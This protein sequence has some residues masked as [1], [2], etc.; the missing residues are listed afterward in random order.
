MKKILSLIGLIILVTLFYKIGFNNIINAF[1]NIN[2]LILFGSLIFS[3]IVLIPPTIKWM[4]IL[5]QQ[6]VN[7]N[8]YTLAKIELIGTFYGIITPGRVGTFIRCFYLKDKIN[9]KLGFCMSSV[10][11]DKLLDMLAI[12][13][14]AFIGVLLIVHRVSGL[15]SSFIL[16]LIIFLATVIFFSSKKRAMYFFNI[17]YNFLIPNKYRKS[18]HGFFHSF[19]N[20]SIHPLHLILPFLIALISYLLFYT[21]TFIVAQA[22]AVNVPYLYFIPLL[23]LATI[24]GMLPVTIAGLGTREATLVGLFSLFNQD[25]SKVIAM[26]LTAFIISTIVPSLLGWYFSMGWEND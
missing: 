3:V 13:F 10:V 18:A 2:L 4:L 21:L 9:K 20:N 19:Y 7:I 1:T 8:W 23:S 6:D 26:S 17:I 24:I 25:P 15:F 11:V 22:F 12:L 5:M 16:F 14:F